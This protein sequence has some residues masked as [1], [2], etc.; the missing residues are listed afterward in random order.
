L[1]L[2]KKSVNPHS[3]KYSYC[4]LLQNEIPQRCTTVKFRTVMCY[5]G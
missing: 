3:Y 5:I 1:L 4:T 2:Q